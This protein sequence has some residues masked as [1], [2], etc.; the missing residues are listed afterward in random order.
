M[1]WI[2]CF[3]KVYLHEEDIPALQADPSKFP[4]A[5][6][7]SGAPL[8]QLVP[9]REHSKIDLGGGVVLEVLDL[10]GHTPHSVVFAD[11]AH[12]CLFTGDAM[13]SGD[14]VLLICP[15]KEALSLAARYRQALEEFLAYMPRF[16]AVCLAGRSQYSGERLRSPPSA[17]FPPGDVPGVQPPAGAGGPGYDRPVRRLAFRGDCL[18][19]GA[20]PSG[21]SLSAWA[22]RASISVLH[23]FRPASRTGLAVGPFAVCKRRPCLPELAGRR[24][25]RSQVLFLR[26]F[27]WTSAG[28]SL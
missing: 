25:E 21:V 12:R 28:K 18:A 22:A 11:D 14:I 26:N 20:D 3:S 10:P 15:E 19:A 27:F 17:G 24:G 4:L 23:N 2:D 9:I 8:P 1:H 6:K 7:D 5:L 13:G 16:A